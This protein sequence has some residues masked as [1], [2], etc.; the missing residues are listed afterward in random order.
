MDSLQ[1]EIIGNEAHFLT[2]GDICYTSNRN[3]ETVRFDTI[4]GHIEDILVE[5]EY[6]KLQN[7]FLEKYWQEFENSEENKLVYTDIFNEY[8][9]LLE[10]H[11][12][13]RLNDLVPNF[14]M[15]AFLEDLMEQKES[16]DGEV[17]EVL[18]T[19]ADFR[20]FKDM[21]LDFRAMK[22]GSSVDFSD[23]ITITPVYFAE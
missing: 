20:S 15:A 9:K 18:L 13:K 21:V 14:S 16:L 5:E 17:F 11:I 4:I 1:N 12:E 7:D 23:G 2:D 8:V 6:H 3:G 10:E 19:L 22:E